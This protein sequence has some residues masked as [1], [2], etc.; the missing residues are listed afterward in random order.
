LSEDG[1]LKTVHGSVHGGLYSGSEAELYARGR[2]DQAKPLTKVSPR[3]YRA[4]VC[5]TSS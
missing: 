3:S 1:F 2:R 4:Q 5:A